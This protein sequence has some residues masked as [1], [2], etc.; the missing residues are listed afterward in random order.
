MLRVSRF[1]EVTVFK[2]GRTLLGR[3]LYPVH[4]FLVDGLLVDTGCR[5]A[6][7]EFLAA[8]SRYRVTAVVNTHHHEDHTG[9]N[10]FFASQGIPVYA[11]EGTLPFVEDPRLIKMKPCQ[12]VA[13]QRP[14][15]A[16]ARP[17]P[18]ELR[19]ARFR[20]RV[21]P[22]PGHSPDHVC[23][24]EPDRGWLFSGDLFLGEQQKLLTRDEDFSALLSSLHRV[25][26]LKPRVLFCS[27]QG[28]VPEA[29]A[30]LQRKI[31]YWE[32]V[33]D[34][35]C[36]L[37]TRGWPVGRIV[38]EVLGPENLASLVATMGFFSKAHLVRAI[39]R[40]ACGDAGQT[41]A[42]ILPEAGATGL[43]ARAGFGARRS[44]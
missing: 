22:T 26:E 18:E 40:G 3:L 44:R 28:A 30:A 36:R 20:F 41:E 5:S 1:E 17:L 8:I 15:P 7:R 14:A 25:L 11:S 37:R 9:N 42:A 4:C 13:W 2:M 10:A 32:E 38:R 35:V 12:H 21:V 39:C 19:T 31:A 6:A 29:T 27:L 16:R 43:G 24:F 23:F 33:R 34:R